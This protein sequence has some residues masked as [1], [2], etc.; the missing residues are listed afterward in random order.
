MRKAI[1]HP[2]IAAVLDADRTPLPGVPPEAQALTAYDRDILAQLDGLVTALAAERAQG[3]RLYRWADQR[4]DGRLEAD[5]LDPTHAKE[6]VLLGYMAFGNAYRA[7]RVAGVPRRFYEDWKRTDPEFAELVLEAHENLGDRVQER[8]FRRVMDPNAVADKASG[9]L[10]I[11]LLKALKPHMFRDDL[12]P[13]SAAA[14]SPSV[15]L[16]NMQNPYLA[17]AQQKRPLPALPSPAAAPTV[18]DDTEP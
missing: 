16:N 3:R 17:L 1:H 13:A 10:S 8:V 5:E 7:C 4:P 11:F 14:T 12:P 2:E 9:V 6:A 18:A 15:R